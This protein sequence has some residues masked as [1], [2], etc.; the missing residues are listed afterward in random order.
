MVDHYLTLLT[1]LFSAAVGGTI[2]LLSVFFTNR[3]NTARLK[4]QLEH[5]SRQRNAELLRNRGEE[6][7]ELSDKWLK[8]LIGHYLRRTFVMQ[9]KITYNQ[10]LDLDIQDGKEDSGNFSR[11][12][13]LIDVYFPSTRPAYNKIIAT[14]NELNK[15]GAAHKH[16]YE[17]GN[18]DGTQF[19]APYIQFQ[20]SI[21]QAGENFKALVLECISGL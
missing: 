3:S 16:E 1:A 20:N 21:E 6:L 19:V 12:A 10:C 17:N 13:M 18:V 9:C 2:A 7:Y 8:K 11:I 14:R 5:E 4:I 15:I